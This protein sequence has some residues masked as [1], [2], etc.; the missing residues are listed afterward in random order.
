MEMQKK[1]M[2]INQ[3]KTKYMTVTTTDCT[4]GPAHIEI[5][6][7]KFEVV[8]SFTYI[9]SEVN[10]K[11]DVSDE[12]RKRILSAN[13]CLHGLRQQLKSQLVPKETRMIT[14]KVLVCL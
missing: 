2:Q 8:H 12:I 14:Y 10:C 5:G 1:K 11:N 13:R 4:N 7:C 6:S 3:N 9:E